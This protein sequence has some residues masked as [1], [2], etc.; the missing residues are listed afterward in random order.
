VRLLRDVTYIISG[1][2]FK[3]AGT[4]QAVPAELAQKLL[5]IQPK[6][7]CGGTLT[8]PLFERVS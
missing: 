8:Q 6:G 2:V 7:C 1:Y 5:S 4:E 3:G